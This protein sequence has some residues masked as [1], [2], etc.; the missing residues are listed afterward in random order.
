MYQLTPPALSLVGCVKVMW[1]VERDRGGKGQR[2]KAGRGD[3]ILLSLLLLLFG[4][5][6]RDWRVGEGWEGWGGEN[7]ERFD[8]SFV[9]TYVP[10]FTYLPAST[11]VRDVGDRWGR[12]L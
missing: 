6:E 10:T 8:R 4:G 11:R 7:I 5:E 2:K 1:C 3:I 12:V 9:H